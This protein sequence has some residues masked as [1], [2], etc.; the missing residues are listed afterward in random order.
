M[1]VRT[2]PR[3]AVVWCLAAA[4][5]MACEVPDV[6]CDVRFGA[7]PSH[8]DRAGDAVVLAWDVSCNDSSKPRI[9]IEGVA[10]D[11][12]A[13]GSMS[14]AL[15]DST[16]FILKVQSDRDEVTRRALVTVAPPLPVKGHQVKGTVID[17]EGRPIAGATVLADGEAFETDDTGA[18]VANV[19]IPYDATV[20]GTTFAG[21]TT[22]TPTLTVGASFA[23]ADVHSAFVSVRAT[24]PT[25]IP[26]SSDARTVVAVMTPTFTNSVWNASTDLDTPIEARWSGAA[27]STGRL[28]A[29]RFRYSQSDELEYHAWGR[30]EPFI[31]T[32]GEQVRLPAMDLVVAQLQRVPVQVHLPHGATHARVS[33]AVTYTGF[34]PFWMEIMRMA[35]GEAVPVP[36]IEPEAM[37][38]KISAGSVPDDACACPGDATVFRRATEL[39]LAPVVLP[40]PPTLHPTEGGVLKHGEVPRWE[41]S[42]NAV[43]IVHIGADRSAGVLITSGR[44]LSEMPGFEINRAGT[45]AHQGRYWWSV[46]CLPDLGTTDDAVDGDRLRRIL[47]WQ[48]ATR[49]AQSS[50]VQFTAE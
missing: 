12:A 24:V 42:E 16:E 30:A 6:P 47:Q 35:P 50:T 49:F 34:R 45:G 7:S 22:S 3:A 37:W 1:D 28:L 5:F 39:A 46:R 23:S 43:C 20:L 27:E 40:D 4:A 14:V 15:L 17:I 11:V 18:F 41:F 29:Y 8:V 38:V 31:V 36:S 25:D 48:T 26:T 10:D 21:L 44:Q 33:H 2:L 32:V 13:S 9:S 19:G